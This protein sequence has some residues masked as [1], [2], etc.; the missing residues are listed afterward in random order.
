VNRATGKLLE[1]EE[2]EQS[3]ASQCTLDNDTSSSSTE[4]FQ[5][6]KLDK[7]EKERKK[8]KQKQKPAESTKKLKQKRKEELMGDGRQQLSPPLG[9]YGDYNSSNYK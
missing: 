5:G 2:S 7:T 4:M 9:S 6:G 1:S 3:V 8:A